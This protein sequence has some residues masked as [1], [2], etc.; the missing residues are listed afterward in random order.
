MSKFHDV[1]K[2]NFKLVVS[3]LTNKNYMF[4]PDPVSLL[5]LC[6]ATIFPMLYTLHCV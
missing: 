5:K 2:D 6:P 1:T 4:D 3:K